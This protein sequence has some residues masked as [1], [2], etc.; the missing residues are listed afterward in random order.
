MVGGLLSSAT[1]PCDRR[2]F[3][4]ATRWVIGEL[5]AAARAHC[6]DLKILFFKVA[7]GSES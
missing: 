1:F 7:E 4:T 3:K 5:V 2:Q 6:S